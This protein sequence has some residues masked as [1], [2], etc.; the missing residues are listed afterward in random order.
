MA[1]GRC[2]R[3]AAAARGEAER[4]RLA[5][6][7]EQSADAVVI[8]DDDGRDRV[9][10]P[11]LRAGHRL[12]AGRGPRPEPA[13]PQERRPESGVLRG[14]VGDA[15]ERAVVRRGPDEPAQGR[16]PVPGGGRH[17]ADPRRGRDDHELRRGQARRDA[18]ARRGGRRGADG[19]RA[20]P[21]R[22]DPRRLA[23]PGRPRQPPPRRSAG[24]S[25]AWPGSRPLDSAYF[26][27]EGPVMPL[28]FVRAD[29]GSGQPATACPSSAAASCAS[30]PAQGHG[31]RPGFAS[32][33]TR[34]TGCSASWAS[35]AIA[36]APVRYSGDAHRD[37]DR[38]LG[39]DRRR[40]AAD[41]VSARPARVRGLRRRARRARHRGPD[42]RR[43]GSASGSPRPSSRYLPAG[44]PAGRRCRDWTR[45][46]A[47]RP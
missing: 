11:G 29:G 14:D 30:G 38:D 2:A 5:V 13:D 32:R 9:R 18:G 39:G 31:S 6:A 35:E 1:S 42:R 10:E 24:R 46:S 28:A 36:Y 33:G 26:T 23:D 8:T 12:L 20:R 44:L 3:R 22:R 41:R 43:A 15:H 34:T 47:T 4:R 16:Q 7:I 27:L 37:P 19:A 21:D 45:T 40:R 25:S 17:L